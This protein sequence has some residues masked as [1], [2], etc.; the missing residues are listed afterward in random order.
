MAHVVAP[1]LVTTW[2]PDLMTFLC[3]AFGVRRSQKGH[4]HVPFLDV[5][6]ETV[7]NRWRLAELL[8][9]GQLL[10]TERVRQQLPVLRYIK[11]PVHSGLHR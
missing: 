2:V 6:E 5:N 9:T 4:Q 10:Y 8:Y 1:L 3:C 7:S 11:V